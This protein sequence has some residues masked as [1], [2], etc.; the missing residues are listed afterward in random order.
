MSGLNQVRLAV[1]GALERAGVKAVPAFEGKAKRYHGAVAAVDVGA[2]SGKPVSL[3]SY[4]GQVY[5]EE[6]GT[7]REL[8]GC[9]LDVTLTIDVWAETAADCETACEKAADVLLTGNL[10]TGLRLQEQSWEAIAWD[11][12]NQMFLRKGKV[13]GKGYFTASLDEE[14]AQLTDFNLKGVLM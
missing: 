6:I 3:G 12:N 10:P 1:I 7:V 14:S 9:Q 11:R 8:Y 4:L 2:V 13:G 5:D